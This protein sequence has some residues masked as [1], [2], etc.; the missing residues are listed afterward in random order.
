[1]QALAWRGVLIEPNPTIYPMLV[2]N[3][4]HDITV[5]AAICDKYR[6]VHFNDA[7]EVG[8]IV[9]FMAEE[10]KEQFKENHEGANVLAIPCIPLSGI[11]SKLGITHI[12]FWSLD[13]ESAELLVLETFD[14][15][16]VTVD[17]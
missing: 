13:V 8:G 11:L 16:A 9:E 17:V 6:D 12:D 1:M 4:P 3:R 7:Q 15:R 14:W 2:A 10:F 5:N